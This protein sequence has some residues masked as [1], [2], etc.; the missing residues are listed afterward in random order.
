MSHVV[1]TIFP[2]SLLLELDPCFAVDSMSNLSYDIYLCRGTGLNFRF[3]IGVL[4]D[5]Q[6]TEFVGF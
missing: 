4:Q 3:S 5:Y 2:R 1:V 6:A